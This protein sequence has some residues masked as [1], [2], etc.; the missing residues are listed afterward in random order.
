[1]SCLPFI[2]QLFRFGRKLSKMASGSKTN[3]KF[4]KLEESVVDFSTAGKFDKQNNSS[5]SS[6]CFV[7]GFSSIST[8]PN[9][10]V[11]SLFNS[12]VSNLKSLDLFDEKMN[13]DEMLS[14]YS[15][16]VDDRFIKSPSSA[17]WRDCDVKNCGFE[18]QVLFQAKQGNSFYVSA[19]EPSDVNSFPYSPLS[20]TCSSN[21]TP[22]DI[23][24]TTES[25]NECLGFPY[26]NENGTSSYNESFSPPIASTPLQ[27]RFYDDTA[28]NFLCH[29]T[30]FDYQANGFITPQQ[31]RSVK[32][33]QQKEFLAS[34]RPQ[35][36]QNGN[37]KNGYQKIESKPI[38]NKQAVKKLNKKMEDYCVFCKNNNEEEV[39]YKSHT[40]RDSK[41]RVLCPILR[42]YKCPICN[43]D[44]DDAHTSKYCPKKQIITYED[45]ARMDARKTKNKYF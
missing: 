18:E 8:G 44:G 21:S 13:I 27:R 7:S 28:F 34:S 23:D 40:V 17:G 24:S 6:G 14:S 33:D 22:T 19:L 3:Q 35:H 5:N 41:G 30:T 25:L 16:P 20:S 37:A 42:V 45:I 1:M 29:V 36:Y 9:E 32:Y 2:K 12:L 43:A 39:V 4:M 38:I 31:V 15:F 26:P 10:G 11:S